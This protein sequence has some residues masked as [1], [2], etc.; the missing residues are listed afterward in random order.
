MSARTAMT[1][2]LDVLRTI[3]ELDADE[4]IA[5]P[6]VAEAIGELEEALREAGGPQRTRRG[7]PRTW[8]TTRNR[9]GFVRG[10]RVHMPDGREATFDGV[11]NSRDVY[12]LVGST[13]ITVAADQLTP[14]RRAA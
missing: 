12:V 9:W 1:K 11:S 10:Q 5:D 8:D 13:R 4:G 14:G 7:I 3:R 6:D 2:A